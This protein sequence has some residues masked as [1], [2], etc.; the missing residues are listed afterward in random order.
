MTE[1]MQA[2]KAI[3]DRAVSQ[4]RE[5]VDSVQ[6]II[7]RQPEDGTGNTQLY[8]N[9]AGNFYARQASV[10]EW[11][12]VQEQYQRNWAKRQDPGEREGG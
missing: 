6:I 4:I 11:L 9:G 10:R 2:I 3:V 7:T 12:I 1:E 5:H 8:E